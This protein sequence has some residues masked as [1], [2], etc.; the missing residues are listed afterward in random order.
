MGYV[1]QFWNI[2]EPLLTAIGAILVGIGS[3]GAISYWLFKQFS[4]RWLAARFDKQLATYKHEQQKELE[5][6][7]HEIN[8]VFDRTV[9]LHQREF[10]V[11]PEAWAKLIDAHGNVLSFV[12]PLQQYPD[13]DRRS[14]GE[15]EDFLKECALTEFEKT[16]L[17]ATSQKTKYF[18]DKIFWYQLKDIR[19]SQRDFMFFLRRNGIFI[20]ES[21]KN[22][23]R[24][25]DDIIWNALREHQYNHQEKLHPR[26]SQS[27]NKLL[28]ESQPL[29]DKLELQVQQRLWNT[30]LD[31][32]KK[33]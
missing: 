12:S 32:E 11:L 5:S 4:E 18:A 21:M 27:I 31:A 28:N 6:L 24:E 23:F 10:E 17:R 33:K 13:L 16:E 15:L 1:Q 19:Q 2:V 30:N 3:I 8:K 29:I 9:K 14:I 22:Q 20:E 25:L 7:K 26:L